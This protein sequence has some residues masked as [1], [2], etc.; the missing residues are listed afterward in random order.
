MDKAEKKPPVLTGSSGERVVLASTSRSRRALLEAGGVPFDVDPALVDED[1]VK[2]S[3]RAENASATDI[4]EVLA[5]AK[6]SR[7]SG[8]H[9]GRMVLGADQV[10]ECGGT[11]YDK[12]AT[13]M[14]AS[15][16]LKAL[17]GRQHTLV[18]HAVVRRDGQR[19][20]QASD[21]A[22]MEMRDVSD[23]FIEK[24]LDAA[25]GEVLNGPGAYR[26]EELGVQLFRRVRGDHFTIL[27]LPLLPLLDFLRENR[28]LM[29]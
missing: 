27:G 8:R 21:T 17:R 3:L 18:S 23:A 13:R 24:Y 2:R 6:A 26:V 12:P 20:W 19:L 29:T 28:I 10:L 7:V 14:E 25:G 11:Q 1:E 9:P 5:D 22:L 15:A 4:A 16:Q